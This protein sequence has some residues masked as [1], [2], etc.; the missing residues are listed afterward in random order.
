MRTKRGKW[1]WI[2]AVHR[3]SLLRLLTSTEPIPPYALAL[4]QVI[5]KSRGGSS[6]NAAMPTLYWPS[7][8]RNTLTFCGARTSP[9]PMPLQAAYRKTIFEANA[10]RV[11]A[12]NSM[13]SSWIM[14]LTQW[15][16]LTADEFASLVS[17]SPPRQAST[18]GAPRCTQTVNA[19]DTV[20]RGGYH[21]PC[22]TQSCILPH[23]TFLRTRSM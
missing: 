12:H 23:R 2:R 21:A 5:F 18:A 9:D 13:D 20:L 17:S 11:R 7:R 14:G 3:H 1:G 19:R 15:A 10:E 22:S 16:D 4:Q 8:L 6:K